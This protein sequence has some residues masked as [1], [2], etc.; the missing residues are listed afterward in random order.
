M[1]WST[2][3]PGENQFMISCGGIWGQYSETS[4]FKRRVRFWRVIFALIMSICWSPYHR[5][6]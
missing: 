5:N 3:D 2:D 1:V 6:T 4:R